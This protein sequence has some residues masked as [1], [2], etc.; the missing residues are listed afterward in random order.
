M[1]CYFY[2]TIIK[3][4]QLLL[5]KKIAIKLENKML[6]LCLDT[7]RFVSYH[8]TSEIQKPG[9]VWLQSKF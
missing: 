1:S 3:K 9:D 5:Q 2:C 7:T 4:K 8:I 6:K